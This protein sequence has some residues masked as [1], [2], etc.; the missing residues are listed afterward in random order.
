MTNPAAKTLNPAADRVLST[1]ADMA[2]VDA[3]AVAATACIS[4]ATFYALKAAGQGPK[5][6][7]HGPQCV[8]YRL[9]DVR[10]WMA[11]RAATGSAAPQI[12]Q[13]AKMRAIKAAGARQPKAAR[14]AKAAQ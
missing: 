4:V 6:I 5:A 13:A 14:P 11:S 8:R 3:K 9:V 7:H 12:V 1:L 10:E 2:E